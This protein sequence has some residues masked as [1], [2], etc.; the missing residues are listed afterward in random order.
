M[1]TGAVDEVDVNRVKI[2][3]LVKIES[4]AVPG[5]AIS[6]R[7][8]GISAE[9]DGQGRNG[10]APTFAV[11][12]TFV[13]TGEALQQTIRIGMSARM[14]I[15]TYSN[16]QS[17]ILPPTA[18]I[19]AS[20]VPKVRLQDDDGNSVVPITLGGSFPEGIEVLSGL[21]FGDRVLSP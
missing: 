16:P 3:Q 19:D 15:E 20:T 10:E 13:A 11:R 12:A 1:V 8:V 6:G 4:D 14:T 9:A 17:I 5:G 7:I 21:K 2:G 18:I